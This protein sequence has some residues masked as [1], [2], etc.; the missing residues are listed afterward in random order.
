MG[1]Y[2]INLDTSATCRTC[3]MGSSVEL[4]LDSVKYSTIIHEVFQ[5]SVIK[6]KNFKSNTML[7]S[8]LWQVDNF[9]EMLITSQPIKK[10]YIVEQSNLF[11][12]LWE[13]M[14]ESYTE[15]NQSF[16]HLYYILLNDL[17]FK[18]IWRRE[19]TKGSGNDILKVTNPTSF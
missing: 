15:P 18:E 2:L 10:N 9:L 1:P 14:I 19:D 12:W 4:K 8:L 3:V 17:G 13:C 5:R 7:N 6:L 11:P 16:S